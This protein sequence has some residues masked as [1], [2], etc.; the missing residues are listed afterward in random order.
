MYTAGWLLKVH[1]SH[2]ALS[3]NAAEERACSRQSINT[4]GSEEHCGYILWKGKTYMVIQSILTGAQFK[5]MP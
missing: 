2:S 4:V 3:P 1:A 5:A